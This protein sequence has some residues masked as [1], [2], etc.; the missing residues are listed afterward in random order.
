MET[1]IINF[2]NG[3]YVWEDVP[4]KGR[5]LVPYIEPIKPQL[6]VKDVKIGQLFKASNGCDYL[7]VSRNSFNISYNYIGGSLLGY[8]PGAIDKDG[9]LALN[10]TTK[11]MAW[12]KSFAPVELIEGF[13]LNCVPTI[14]LD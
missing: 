4:R 1:T 2:E 8:S 3:K 5:S 6:T 10:L 9:I 11:T 7:R 14:Q 13:I 12:M